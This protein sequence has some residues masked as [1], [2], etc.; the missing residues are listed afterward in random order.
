M[1]QLIKKLLNDKRDNILE[2]KDNKGYKMKYKI[3]YE[4]VR[5]VESE[6]PF[7]KDVLRKEL[8][9]LKVKGEI[10]NWLV[11]GEKLASVKVKSVK[12]IK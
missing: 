5:E 12:E 6:E 2:N 7:P 10:P 11:T 8:L 1:I 9:D 4:V 3:M